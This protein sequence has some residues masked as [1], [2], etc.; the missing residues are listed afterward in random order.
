[1]EHTKAVNEEFLSIGSPLVSVVVPNYNH[2]R[3]LPERLDSIRN[4]TFQNFELIYLDDASTDDSEAVFARYKQAHP[5]LSHRF[6]AQIVNDV[7]SGTPFAQWNRGVQMARGK[8][9]WIA[10]ADDYADP[11]LLERLVGELERD[12]SVSIAYCRSK[13]VSDGV[14]YDWFPYVPFGEQARFWESDYVSAGRDEIEYRLSFL[15][16]IANASAT[17]FRR[18]VYNSVG[19]ADIS[20]RTSGDH[21]VWMRM[22][23]NTRIAF[24][25]EPLNFY[26]THENSV[27]AHIKSGAKQEAYVRESYRLL[28][29]LRDVVRLPDD[30]YER[31]CYERAEYIFRL[32]TRRQAPISTIQRALRIAR[33][34]DPHVV[35][36]FG[37]YLRHKGAGRLAMIAPRLASTWTL[38]PFGAY[39]PTEAQVDPPVKAAR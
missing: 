38:P 39:W 7:N 10:E 22:L 3:Y 2:A 34:T 11:R 31:C 6:N 21:L 14:V 19:G 29:Y 17:V 4:Q 5:E 32:F 35:R 33:T 1:M 9:V 20:Y 24:I 30:I 15:N 13:G 12:S 23:E 16:T 18:D 28:E 26:R 27:R 37:D 25:A 8:Y 36:R